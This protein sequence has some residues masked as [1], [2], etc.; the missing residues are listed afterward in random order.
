[1]LPSWKAELMNRAGRS[2]Y[3][4]FVMAARVIYTTMTMELP[5]W[6]I[7]AIE[8]LLAWAKVAQPKELSEIWVGLLGLDGPG[9]R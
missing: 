5:W 7:K 2:V 3:V 4:Q 6:A 1:M 9:C 8:K